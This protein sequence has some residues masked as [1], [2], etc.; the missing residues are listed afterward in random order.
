MSV[1][2]TH[3]STILICNNCGNQRTYRAETSPHWARKRAV[4]HADWTSVSIGRRVVAD[5]C[6]SCNFAPGPWPV[7][8]RGERRARGK[9][10]KE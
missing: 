4:L 9:A 10:I 7:G 8:V 3:V 1:V 2:Q 5:L 6:E